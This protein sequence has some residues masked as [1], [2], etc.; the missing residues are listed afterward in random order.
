MKPGLNL[1]QP[2]RTLGDITP[3]KDKNILPPEPINNHLNIP[4]SP[5]RN[6][7]FKPQSPIKSLKPK[8]RWMKTADQEQRH[9]ET[10]V[11]RPSDPRPLEPRS[12]APR[13]II[14]GSAD[15]ENLAMPIRW[16]EN[17][18]TSPL[19][20][21]SRRVRERNSTSPVH[22]SVV[23]ALVDLSQSAPQQPLNLSTSGNRRT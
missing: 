9:H 5:I 22:W 8:K 10:I 11:V 4:Q 13:S 18:S 15:E 19:P 1:V 23:S 17:E 20:L 16:N 7:A 6:K 2:R 21:I 14:L 12:S 3:K